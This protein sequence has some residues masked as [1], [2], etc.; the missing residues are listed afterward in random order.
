[1]MGSL[2]GLLKRGSAYAFIAGAYGISI[3]SL[4]KLSEGPDENPTKLE[5]TIIN[6]RDRY[7]LYF[8]D[9]G[10][11]GILLSEGKG[12]NIGDINGDSFFDFLEIIDKKIVYFQNDKKGNF[13]RRDI[14]I[15]NGFMRLDYSSEKGSRIVIDDLNGDKRADII[16]IDSSRNVRFFERARQ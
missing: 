9:R 10:F 3:I 7:P 12:N 6:E 8:I 16:L 15:L 4:E 2:I 5:E 14:A 13:Y 11:I 1:M